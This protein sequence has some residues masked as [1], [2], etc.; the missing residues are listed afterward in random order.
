MDGKDSTVIDFKMFDRIQPT[1]PSFFTIERAAVLCSSNIY[2]S[3]AV[4]LYSN[5]VVLY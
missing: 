3:G 5:T 2:A 4:I 1:P